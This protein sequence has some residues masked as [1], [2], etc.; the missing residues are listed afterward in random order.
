METFQTIRKLLRIEQWYKNLI[1][2]APVLFATSVQPWSNLLLGFIGLCAIS[3]VTYIANDWLDRSKDRL[4]PTKKNRPLASGKVTGKEALAV[5]TVLLLIVVAVISQVGIFYG[6]L[7]GL[8][9]LFTTAYSLGLK[10]LPILDLLL[11]GA[12]F[13]L[14]MAAGLKEPPEA[15]QIPYFVFLFSLILLFLTHK[16]RSDIKLLGS[17][18]AAEHKP[19]LRYYTPFVCHPIRIAAYLL[20]VGSSYQ[21]YKAGWPLPQLILPLALIMYTSAL[22]IKDP[23]LVIKPHYLLKNKAWVALLLLCVIAALV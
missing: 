12:N 14:R 16:R 15:L 2:F 11:I 10:N 9:F 4:H 3:S 19:V 23:A 17:T 21:L 8:Y 20:I 22:F 13:M 18:R 7:I 6:L 1:I 5:T